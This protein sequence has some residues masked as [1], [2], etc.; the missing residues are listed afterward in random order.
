MASP[1]QRSRPAAVWRRAPVN[2]TQRFTRFVKPP[3][4]PSRRP[5]IEEIEP[6]IL[7]AADMAAFG[8]AAPHDRL[9]MQAGEEPRFDMTTASSHA[10]QWMHRDS[11]QRKPSQA[12]L[13][14]VFVDPTAPDHERIVA[15]LLAR[16]ASGG[17]RYEVI[18]LDA[19]RDGVEQVSQAL[20]GRNDVGALHFITHGSAGSFQLA[21]TRF[22]SEL[23]GQRAGELMGWR[24]AL[25]GDA[26]ILL[27]G[28]NLA[29][30]AEGSQLVTDLAAVTGADVAASTNRTGSDAAGGDWTLERS[31]G[32][33]ESGI[34]LSAGLQQQL[35]G[36]F[37]TY[38]VTNTN[39][40]GAGSLRQA[41]IDAN[42]NSGTDTINFNISGSG[43][44]IIA[45]TT[46]LP[47]ITGA[48]IIDGTSEPD[49]ATNGNKPIVVIAGSNLGAGVDGLVLSSTADG[50]TIKGLV[51]RDFGGDGIEI[52]AGSNGNTI[53]G[54][55]IGRLLTTGS[56]SGAGTQN[57]G[58]G[59]HVLGANNT[60]GGITSAD[61]NIVSGNGDDGIYITGASATG[62]LVAGN[63][64]GTN[65]AGTSAIANGDNGVAFANGATGNTVGGSTSAYRN[66]IS[67][68]TQDG[69]QAEFN[70]DGNTIQ[71]NYI[72]LNA[73][74]TAA[75]ANSDAGVDIDTASDNTI[76]RDNVISG[77][78][79]YG[80][81]ISPSGGTSPSGTQIYGNIVGLN[82]GGTAKI[83]N[84]SAGIYLDGTTGTTI[85]GVTAADRNVI[86]GNSGDGIY[87]LGYASGTTIRGNY[88]GTASDGSTLLGNGSSSAGIFI[89]EGT[90]NT[91]GGTA[92]NAGNQI[93]GNTD[94]VV[95]AKQ[96]SNQGNAILGN[97]IH[98]NTQIGIDLDNDGSDTNN[99]A[100]NTGEANDQID[101]PVFTATS[102]DGTTLTVSG[103]VGTAAGDT[104]FANVRVEVFVTDTDSSG[105]GEGKR[106]VG[107]IMT[108]S[109]NGNFSG[110]LTVSGLVSGDKITG[111]STDT[112]NNTSEFGAN[113]T[114]TFAAGVTVTPT[115]G[116][117]TTEAGGTAQFSVVLNKAPTANVTISVTTGNALE[118]TASVSTLVFTSANWNV[119]QIVT[120]TGANETV[121]DGNRAYTI[122][123]G[124]AVSADG[125]YNGLNPADVSLTN[126]DNDTQSTI[127]VTTTSDTS[128]GDTSSLYALLSNKGADGQISLREAI[129]AANNTTN[130]AGGADT[131]NF[132]ITG[133]GPHVI[134]P[135]TALPT[136]TGALI[137]DGTSE[138]D[139]ATN[140]NKPIVVID[141]NNLVADGLTLSSTADGSTIKG[142]VIRD[143]S[144]NGI[145]V[146]VG[147]DGNT[148][149]GNYVGALNTS[150]A[151]VTGEENTSAGIYVLGANTTVGGTTS[152][153]R[154][155]I[156]GNSYSGLS[157]AGSGASG[158]AVIGNYVGVA[159]DGSTAVSGSS[160]GVVLWNGASGNRIGGTT[161]GEGNI[162][163]NAGGIGVLVDSNTVAGQTAIVGN[164][165][166]ANSSL[167]IDLGYN[168]VTANDSGDSD[169]GPNGLQN[170]AVLG[171]ATVAG[172]NL[173]VAGSLNSA[174]NT[175]YR[176]EL[177]ASSTADGSGH[178]EGQRYLGFV[179]VTTDGSGN[180]TFSTTV[181]GAAV[182]A[183][184]IV[185]STTTRLDG[186]LNAV[187]TSEFSANVIAK[188]PGVTVTPTSGLIT[189]EGGGTA[190]FS[191]VLDTA[192]TANVTIAI[193]S[194]N[195]AEGTVS[196]TLLTFTTANWNVAQTV[197]VTGV[198]DYANDGS[199]AYTV[200]TGATSSSDSSYNGLAVSD[201]SATNQQVANLA[202]VNSVPGTQTVA[203][204]NTLTFSSGGG[205]A[206]S[207]SDADAGTSSSL[208]V[209][210][211]ASQ[212]T[213]SL[214][215]IAGLSFSTG[216]GSADA[217]MTFTGTASAINAA[218]NGL[219]LAPGTNYNGALTISLTTNDNGNT[220]TGGALSDSD[221]VNVTVTAVNDAPNT[222]NR[223]VTTNEDTAYTF[224]TSDFAFSDVDAGASLAAVRI[225]SLPGAGTLR[226]NGVAVTANQS[227][228]VADI[229][230]GLLVFTPAADANGS[231]YA[232]FNFRV[233]DGSLESSNATVTVNVTAVNDAPTTSNRTVATNE[234]T[235]YVFATSDFAF[236]DVDAGAS[237]AS[238]RIVSI[239]AAGTLTL[240]GAAVT[241][242][243]SITAADI[244][245]GLLVF[246]PAAN[247]NGSGY[248]SFNF[249]VSDGSLE[250]ANAAVTVNVTAVNDAPTTSSRT[251]TTNEDTA[252][253]FSTADFAF[254]DV[255]AG[256]SLASVRI[257][258]VP[259]A[260]ALTL[261]GVV[262]TANQ[263][264]TAA[265]ITSG[266][267]VF[268]PAANANG[269]GYTSFNFRVSD[270]T[271]ESANATITVDVTA[272]NDVPTT[273]NRTVTTN[274]DAA[275]TFTTADFAFTDVD[276][277]ASLASV[278]IVSVPAAGTLTLNGV[279]V[280]ANQS[281]T[282]ADITSGLLVFTPA[283]D[284]NGTGYASFNFRVS[285]GTAES[286][287]GAITVNVT[288]ANDAP[289]TSNRTVTTNEDT[290]YTFTTADFA[291]SDVD[292]G[293]SLASVRIVSLPGAGT[294]TLNGVAVT[295]NQ[296]VT[297]ADI[298]AGLLVF[299][300]AANA[301]GAS[302]ASFNFKVSDGTAESANAAVTV[303]VTAVNDAPTTSNRT[304][305]TNED[306][307]YVFSA[308]DFAFS[309]V[310]AGASLASVRIVSVPAVGTLTLNGVAVTANQ[311]VTA[312]DI[313]SG[314][315]VFT[316]AA[317]AN[318]TGYASFN[319]KVSDGSLESSNA[320]V[321]VNVTAVNDA[322]T[323][324]NRSVTTNEDT[325]YVFATSDFAFSD[326]DAG[327][328]LAS[329]RIVSIPTA[330][331]L[332]LNGAAVSA[333]QSITAAD[334][335]SGLL[336]F[337][338]AANANGSGYAS[339]NFRVSDGTAE[340]ATAAI[341]VNVSAVNDAPT[342]S[343][344]TVTA[345]EDTAYTF[346]TADFAFSDVDA[347]ASLASVRIVSVPG[348]GTLTL[349]GVAVAANQSITAADIASGLLVFTP[350]ADANGAG[351][352]S[353]NFRVSD[354]AAESSNAAITLNVTA[355]NDA[356]TTGNR[357]VTTNEDTAYTFSTADFAF[358]DVDA[359]ASLASV[360][361]V[362][363]PGAGTLTLNGAAVTANQSI[364]V[365]DI[366]AGLLVF[367]PAANANGSGYTSF[368][369]RV[370]DGS[371]E[372]ANATVMVDITAVN[373]APTTSSRTVSTNEDTAYTFT[374]ADFAFNDVD[375]GASLASVRIVSVPGAGTLTLN[376]AAV[377]ANQSIT[378]ADIMSGLL[379][380]TPAANANGSA[381]ASF[382][383]RV[384]D[385][386]AESANAAITVDVTAVN[387]AP[388]TS[389]RTVTTNED[390]AYTF[391]TADFAFSDV[392]AG[393][394]LASVRIVSV[395]GAG[396]L[397]LNGIAVA[398]NQSISAADIASGLLVFTPAADANGSG[399]ASFNFR[400]SDSTAESANAAITVDVTA[401]NDAPTTS[402]RTVTT[403]E[404][405]AYTFSTADFAFSDVDAGA[406]LASVRIVS[407]PGAGTLTLN[408]AAVIANQSIT[409]ADIASGLLVFTPAANANGT[410]HA[411][412]NFR[413]SDGASESANAAITVDVTAVNDAPTTSNR[414]VTT[415]E[416][417][418]Y[419]F[420]TSDFAFSD[421]DTGASLASVRVVALPAAGTLTLNGVAVA[422]NQNIA[423]AD[424]AA[425][426]LVFTPAADANGTAY[427]SFTFRV[428]DGG[429]QSSV[430]TITVDVT[431]VNDAPTAADRTVTM[432]EDTGYAFSLGDFAFADVDAG[433]SLDSV[434]IT[435]LPA[436]GSLT[437][438]GVAVTANQSVAAADIAAGLLVFTPAAD[439]N[440]T[441][442]ASFMFRVSDGSL[443]SS[444][445]TMTV[446]VSAVNDAPTTADRTVTTSEDTAYTFRLGDFAFSDVDAG[447]SLASVRIAVLPAAGTLTLNG[448]AVTANQSIAAADIAAGLLVFTP[449]ADANGAA[450]AS[451]TFRVSDGSLQS[452]T[453]TMA[454][455]VTA[456]NDAPT[457]TDRTVTTN[458]DTDYTFTLADFA[459]SDV[460]VGSS[461][462]S[463]RIAA[464]PA[465]GTL[466]LNGVAVTAN[467]SIAAADIAAG[468]LVFTPAADANGASYAS[469]TFRVS[470]GSLQSSAAAMTVDVTAVNDVPTTSDRTVATNE[471]TGYTF[472]LGDF[473]FSD[474]DAG[475]SLASVRI[476]ALPAAGTLTLNGVAVTA[477]QSI[478]AADIAAG[479]LVFTPAV[480]ANGT[481]YASFT[482][483]VSDGALQSST[484]TMTVDVTAVND[485][486]TTADRTVATN[487]D[488]GYTFTLSDFA[489]S[490]VDAG[491]SLA[492]V[493]IA[494]LPAAGTL[495]LNG[496][497]VTANQSI[498]AADIAAGLLVFTPAADA[499]GAAYTSFTF[500][501]SDGS[502]QSSTATLTV[503]VSAVND[504]PTTADRTVTTNEDAAY[505]FA[506]SDFAF[507]DADAGASLASVR[508]VA[509]PA[510]GALTLNGV[511][512]TANQSIAAADIAAGLLVFTPAANADGAAYAAFTF[513]VSDGS[514]QSSTATMTVDVTAVND[515]PT[516]ADRTVTTNEDTN[517]TFTL[518]DFA[519]SDVDA[520]ASL[521]SVRITALPA[522]GTLTLNGVAVTANQ[523]IAAADI[524]AGLLVFTPAVNAN[525]T[526]HASFTFRVSDGALQSSTATMTVDVTAVNDAPAT[527]DGTVVTN[528]DTGYT[529]TLADFAFSD[530]DAG[531]SLA[532]VRIV[533]LPAAGTLTLN[534]VAVSANQS[535][536]AADI[537]AGLLVFTPAADANGAAYAAFT[538]RVSDGSL[539]SSTATLTVDVT[540]VNDA[541]TT[542][543]RTVT[544]SE[545]TAYTFSLG[546]FA[547]SDI[548]AGAS[549]ASV[550]IAVL[551]V[552]GTLTLNGVAVGANQSIAAADIAAGLLV[553]TPAA[554][555]NG[556][557][558]ASFTFRVSD[559]S[560]QSSTATMT[561][562]VT[563]VNDA[564]TTADRTV[565]T[566][567][568]TAYTFSLGDFAFSD[569]DAGASLA[570]VRIV[571]L[572]A[573]GTLT[574]NGVAVTANQSV[575][576]AD[577]AA[578]LLVFTPAANANGT[579]YASFTFRVSDGSL[580]SSAA[581]MT[582]DVTAVN[583][584]P[585]TADG[586]VVTNEDTGYTF[587]LAD[588]AFSDVDAGASLVSVR[589]VALP[590]AGSLTLNGVAVSANQSIAAADIAAGLLVFTPAANANGAAYAAFT[591]R[592]GD[593][594]LQSSIATI[595]VD[596]TAINDAPTTADRTVATNEDTG[597]TF[598]LT[599]FA[600][601]DVDAAASLASVR[602]VVLPATGTLTLNGVAVTANQNITAADIA[603]GLLVFTPAANANGAAYASFTFSVSDGSLQSS[604]ATMTVDVTAVNDAPAT[605]DHTVTTN[606]DAGYTFAL[607]DFAFSDADAGA[608]LA[609]VR[610]VAL[611]AAG[612]LTL[613][614]VTIAANQSIAAA[615]IAA[616]LLVFTPSANANGASYASFTFRVSDGSL[617]S[618]AAT[619][620]VDVAAINDAP[621]TADQTVATNED[622]AYTFAL[623]DF[624][625]SD[626]DAGA[627]LSSVRIVALPAAGTLTLNGVAVTANQSVAAADIAAGL[628]VF[629]PAANANGA[630]YASFSFRVSD[631][632]LQSSTAAMTVDV[633]AVN[634]APTT[635][636]RIVTTNEDTAYTFALADFAFSD[637][638]AGA[639]L[640]SVRIVAL[641][642]AGA[643]T[644]NGVAVAANQSIAAAD[645]A[646]GLLVFT[647][648]ANANGA[649]CASFTFRVSDGSLESSSAAITVDVAAVNDAPA[650][651]DRTVTTNEDTA[652]TF[653][654]GDFVFSDV[655][656]GASLA[657]VRITALPAAGTLMLNGVAVTANQSIAAADIA[658][659]LLVFTP[660]A[661][662]NGTAYAAFTFR[663]SDGSLQSSTATLTVDVAAVNDAPA[664]ADRT[665]STNEDTG[666]T[667]TL[668]D[669]A[670]S[671]VDAG[672][673]L[674]SV[675]IAALPAAG[676][677]T[678]NGVAV[679]ANQSISATDI[680]AGLLVFTPAA[681]ANGTAYTSFAFRVSD[682]SLQ[683]S[684]ATMTVD[685]TAVN[686]APTTT[687]RTVTTSEDTGYTF[688]LSDFAFSDADTGA[689]LA[690][691]RIVALP[692][693]GTLTLNGIAVTANQSIAAADI[694]SGLL[695]FTPA[696][697][698]NGSTYT[699]FAFRVS[700]GSLQSA[701]ATMTVD[702]TPV[703]DAPTTADR[704]VT[705]NEDTAYRFSLGDFAFADTDAG[706][707][708]AS[709]RIVA[710]PAAGTLTLNGIAISANQSIAAADIAAGLLLFT[711]DADANG[712]AL[713]SFAFRVSDGSS[714][715]AAATVAIDVAAVNDAPRGISLPSAQIG[716]NA[717]AGGIV[718][719]VAVTDVDNTTGFAFQLVDDADG[720]FVIDAQTGAITLAAGATL[721]FE[722]QAEFE[723]T[724]RVSDAG[725]A[726]IVRRFTISVT[727]TAEAPIARDGRATTDEDRGVVLDETDF[728]FSD[729]DG[730]SHDVVIIGTPDNG[731]LLLNGLDVSAG[732]R[733]SAADLQAGRLVFVPAADANGADFA[734]ILFA[735]SDGTQLSNAA[736]LVI[737]VAAVDDAAVVEVGSQSPLDDDG[738]I[739]L[740]QPQLWVTDIDNA[741]GSLQVTVVGSSG[742]RV[743]LLS[744]P[745]RPITQ[746]TM[747]DLASGQVV[748]V[749]DGSGDAAGLTI[750][751]GSGDVRHQLS[752]VA[753]DAP[754]P[755]P[756]PAPA[757][758]P[759][760]SPSP[761]PAPA[762]APAPSPTPK[763]APAPTPTVPAP[764]PSVT[765]G[766]PATGET[767]APGP[768]VP[769][770]PLRP[771]PGGIDTA[772]S[773]S[774]ESSSR[775][776]AERSARASA[777]NPFRVIRFDLDA[778][779]LAELLS[780]A[781]NAVGRAAASPIELIVDHVSSGAAAAADA[782]VDDA[783]GTFL[784]L[785]ITPSQ[786]SAALLSAGFVWWSL[787][788]AGLISTLLAATPAWRHLDPIPILADAEDDDDDEDQHPPGGDGNGADDDA[789]AE[790]AQEEAASRELF[791]SARTP[792]RP[793]LE[794][795]S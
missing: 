459:F 256:A 183:G 94:G 678:L 514:L 567:E 660:A 292:A 40:S 294:L 107:Y 62:N 124:A 361:I 452:S 427:T 758:S 382:N 659:G 698:A 98:D 167:G 97:A 574:L 76:V 188:A 168:G 44:H 150:G 251:V 691:V 363:V 401:V 48:V 174:A 500:R 672:A 42:A 725:G 776:A 761:S 599:D 343:S 165:I 2:S 192:P 491:A 286:A 732:T 783:P 217:T 597:Y 467:Q 414:T 36:T 197:T 321:T 388:T 86:S 170:F 238:V 537:A 329:V 339:F 405:T 180:A 373:D 30:S 210:L 396:T 618:A 420:S 143:F 119:A 3:R 686:D 271:T 456:V 340:S 5:S 312:A 10:E 91:V 440:G 550:Q 348:A 454:V 778:N 421:V 493:R 407:V 707:S 47:T 485:A 7:H 481:A 146:Q 564:P 590:A 127:T 788:V 613:N 560:L 679:T 404:D 561:V 20:K 250:S 211:T 619:M 378:V 338:P 245:S 198:Q 583:D 173:R 191:V 635:A 190:Q 187:E 4:K 775:G 624:A 206:I 731:R 751:V 518:A 644:L 724:V 153:L 115:S 37:A 398:A 515:A 475:A 477:N 684:T 455:D 53:A 152:A 705:T 568:D 508:I 295:A 471:D 744:D 431:A 32:H 655:D 497:A 671:D 430:A 740:G 579:V 381:Y 534:G 529:F 69:A 793:V 109:T 771:T 135:T 310:D 391:S 569:V 460:D 696:A 531:A 403:N 219:A 541:P 580:Q 639:S 765:P 461:L 444:A 324:S 258:S 114:V 551:P 23:V 379:V 695:I 543:D 488:A 240:N 177:F 631:G 749:A 441:A 495:T 128:D 516:T 377:T 723:V 205:N 688:S 627:S 464:L 448:V 255:D 782:V 45:P 397:T 666:Y 353:F 344:R 274:E 573:A 435:A 334:I 712:S 393:A 277:G 673:S 218:L 126:T 6:R 77:N 463:V 425:G 336:V 433:A 93:A 185:S 18:L 411:S 9:A 614:S 337:T 436:A 484:A 670:F 697:N 511:A 510:A 179:D 242:N 792:A 131:I 700:D 186:S 473:A 241:A 105:K 490:D 677:L 777:F 742:G 26:D 162:I 780:S 369:F 228:T 772:T 247:A 690:S 318:G 658:A 617:Q 164:S 264:I 383:F 58:F 626:V 478:A 586:T 789:A 120:V 332:T 769:A 741:V 743:Y 73:A 470:D 667:F 647:P 654:L 313:T 298:N 160:F 774:N 326:V 645:I 80:I 163:A 730:A 596:V 176:I 136:I 252:Y 474:A 254:S 333:N 642:A 615:D 410:G 302:Y 719:S 737:D 308:S 261:N 593:G 790:L 738:R 487:E 1:Q 503:D 322:P 556:A 399:Y 236:S 314:L 134:T 429:L 668:G 764:S 81:D 476:A 523:S 223:T 201:V 419:V 703:N 366:A 480:N 122:V 735:V 72:G 349:N 46:A 331:T 584:A 784:S 215:G 320:T 685:V 575:A 358:S 536:T 371:L 489:F 412:F 630:A 347:G 68:N 57:Q 499:N 532:S 451:F 465:A 209:T 149:T 555:A 157:I 759:S 239:P 346:T 390:T 547:F 674:A 203:E 482:F 559:G 501:V 285:D 182:S 367:T 576:A 67:G 161:T 350:A 296:S 370:S 443:Q 621:T 155:V 38:T 453:A 335:A 633:T 640:V 781:A 714:Y 795:A 540:A 438:N 315:L 178:G 683:S 577:I 600:F 309:D 118:G 509:L 268:T 651:A 96:S 354:G 708:L 193:S 392:D 280:T 557:A 513:R 71:G 652:Y 144:G 74:G 486:P 19:G 306:T 733:V 548:D 787:R 466:T 59:I 267:L 689:S 767:P 34:A 14:L 212:G 522:A 768:Q 56:D 243:Q 246:T 110:T 494:A 544:T 620:T 571:A 169:T 195:T 270:G 572:P 582:V 521:A 140:G 151:F 90:N 88:I 611:P 395:P 622:T 28:C 328:S 132:S 434:R 75:L 216:D 535:I 66:V 287:N 35:A 356:P 566:N 141:G 235:A 184:E 636:D 244:A 648:A 676:T 623:S 402:N 253:T 202:P 137:I 111:T 549:L 41:I 773:A 762:P 220:G 445:S 230:A 753:T 293:A 384:S 289:T 259:G 711:P 739:V 602:V 669:F 92:T 638:D 694:A 588:F 706:A 462:A 117:V 311:S 726:T 416:D 716:E 446:D 368:N 224:L 284:A 282:A 734:R 542:A 106:Y 204:D 417:T 527:A 437:L 15:D 755:S 301:N 83:A 305:T 757:P 581:T 415:N 641:P 745:T 519:F 22:D 727:D 504:A 496:V 400:V 175:T 387:D 682:G 552:A 469:F 61:R 736:V 49:Y 394:S 283:A 553:F 365:A 208:T 606:E 51:I 229:A 786:A 637:V 717:G 533:A 156:A 50:S 360:R 352:T 729:D 345:N 715:S 458:E 794:T 646:A 108:G 125:S 317:N 748:F 704:T 262:V 718:G 116:L 189:T 281:V 710:L 413:V 554:N 779:E 263:S 101:Q 628:L 300:P 297:A 200:I 266:L 64:V 364:T 145:A 760:P 43:P 233:S 604:T 766:S 665:V 55:Y 512:V 100:Y 746:F 754:A 24:T 595:T 85:G 304:V 213:L 33:I 99:G 39:D 709:V 591:F 634:D 791:E 138:P 657:S 507:S 664:T 355:V 221:T 341:T 643:L 95:I 468:L 278:R 232:S 299:A 84:G 447:A 492:S 520:G 594:S 194:S 479:L 375:A 234:D 612:T 181:V 713:A 629:T 526:A 653:T 376:G 528:E 290:A 587:T 272:V 747:D 457:T 351:Y 12:S 130:G 692:A 763:P 31:S 21:G 52:Q 422:A 25:D 316:P 16:S 426:L 449:A 231:G 785:E 589:I 372:S 525:G 603:A 129:T 214:S 675:R 563:A 687:D 592:V 63:Y 578:G 362:S 423:A 546:D 154:N 113:H 166:Y 307:A 357:T 502:L 82:P 721:N 147:S 260:G 65:A 720:R 70:A 539:Q 133:S 728:R 701:T 222:S 385:G 450:Y 505:T 237:L 359:G 530:I 380:F 722:V 750:T 11:D 325:A 207:V 428:S 607:S 498:A 610:I 374:A 226:L 104:D 158:N 472:S 538:F 196:I 517:Y 303:N 693:A 199:T 442:Y 273:S 770:A 17:V 585:A 702:V 609:S 319:F 424:I 60:I 78:A 225:V 562:D 632:S 418:A 275:Y 112:S 656:V 506:L 27:Y 408:G 265:D 663:V 159:A 342:T 291:F 650:T 249:R 103:Y 389:N 172:S 625:F 756:T 608:S 142:L 123:L 54:N 227:V 605:T 171:S 89:Q 87:I 699:S 524:A 432:N 13:E 616:G 680:A 681:N 598:A 323:T 649:A 148:I 276:A 139:F 248:T 545:D 102:W 386:T 279:V 661:D 79:S 565:A 121:V 409:A 330:G 406:S 288:A 752:F 570:S 257:V 8:M 601:A 483:R 269:S 439:A 558:Y 327:A 29:A 662:A